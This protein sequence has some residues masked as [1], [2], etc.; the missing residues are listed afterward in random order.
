MRS[1]ANA[2]GVCVWGSGGDILACFMVGGYIL[3]CSSVADDRPRV[4]FYWKNHVYINS[5]LC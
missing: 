3:R 4:S 2:E 5:L 1:Q